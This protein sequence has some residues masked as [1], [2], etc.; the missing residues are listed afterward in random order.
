MKWQVGQPNY[1][2][3]NSNHSKMSTGSFTKNIGMGQ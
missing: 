3:G 1:K 2:R